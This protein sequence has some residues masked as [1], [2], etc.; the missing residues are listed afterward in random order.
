MS[1]PLPRRSALA[2]LAIVVLLTA[3]SSEPG[4][5]SEATSDTPT[6]TAVAGTPSAA[7]D[8]TTFGIAGL[9]PPNFPASS[10]A[11]WRTFFEAVG[12]LGGTVG[13]YAQVDDLA[14]NQQ[15]A[16]AGGLDVLPVTGFHGDVADGIRITTDFSDPAQRDAFLATLL[17]FVE[18]YRPPYLGVGNEVNRV[19]EL[20]PAAFDAWV[21]ALPAI[22]EAVHAT[23]PE[24][25][26]FATFQYEFLRGRDALTGAGRAEDWTPFEVVAP[27]LDL[28]AFTSY[29]FFGAEDPTDLPDDYYA[30][31]AEH[32]D[33][34]VGFTELGWPSAPIAPLIGSAVEDLGGTPEEQQ[35]FVERL[36]ALLAPLGPRFAMWVWVY[37]TPGLGPV[38]ESLG[39]ASADESPKPAF[40]AWRALIEVE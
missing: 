6:P 20:E 33:L 16:L 8:A 9:I 40:E 3:C 26:V 11:D 15:V 19:W 14:R 21:A 17:A 31:I 1:R 23:S 24:T 37:D 12:D 5:P 35:R 10:D 36:E 18:A 25:R 32:T 28:V 39:L 2:S 27:H 7:P 30:V 22:V 29:P 34:P 13:N 4:T 38:F